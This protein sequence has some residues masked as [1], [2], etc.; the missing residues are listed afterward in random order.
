[1]LLLLISSL[2][3]SPVAILCISLLGAMWVYLKFNGLFVFGYKYYPLCMCCF[4]P[5][6]GPYSGILTYSD[7]PYRGFF[8]IVIYY[9]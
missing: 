9:I 7:T 2:C 3:S 1:M 8:L 4:P 6:Y 5:Y